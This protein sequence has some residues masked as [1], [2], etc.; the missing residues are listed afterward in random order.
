MP[1]ALRRRQNRG[2]FCSVT[3]LLTLL[4]ALAATAP[5][6][7]APAPAA[8]SLVGMY[9]IHQMEM[10]GGLELQPN[11]HFRYGFTYGA[12]DE[13]AEGDWTFD[14]SAVHLTSNPMPDEPTF[15]LIRDMPAPKCDFSIS[16]DWGKFGWSSPPKVLVAYQDSPRD[17]HFADVDEKGAFHPEKCTVI[18]VFP[19]VPMF[20]V[21]GEALNVSPASGHH[22]S[23]R[24]RPNDLGHVAFR[25]EPLKLDGSALVWERFDAEI[26]FLR[27][28]P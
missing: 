14:G 28:R 9:E 19:L 4:A 7:A 3:F 25:S 23:V 6:A 20:N 2:S 21:P 18:S 24:F 22:L 17:L 8:P 5:T 26:R 12:V 13:G 10:A 1:R 15:D 11:G 27:V 16:A